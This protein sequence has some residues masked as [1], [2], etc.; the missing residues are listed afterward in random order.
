MGINSDWPKIWREEGEEY[1]T[2]SAATDTVFLDGQIMLMQS[3][4]AGRG[5]TWAE[6]VRRNF[7]TRI[8]ARARAYKRVIVGFDNYDQVPEYTMS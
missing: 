3:Q 2:A 7:T 1:V 5:M 8:D 6:F 4:V